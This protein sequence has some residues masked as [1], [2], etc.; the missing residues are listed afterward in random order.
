MLHYL[1]GSATDPI[2]TPA[3]LPH[4][5]N[6]KGR[7]GSGYVIAVSKKDKKPEEMYYRWYKREKEE[8]KDLPLGAVQ[9]CPYVDG[10]EVANMVGQ[11]DTKPIDGE[12]P[13]RYESLR[14]AL[15]SVYHYAGQ[16]NLTV[17]M[18]R[19]GAQRSGGDWNQIEAIIKEEMGDIETYVYTLPNEKDQWPQKYE[20]EEEYAKN[21]KN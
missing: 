12:P 1:I 3:L 14:Q 20:N 7:W 13:I 21:N 15:K 18:P 11:H 8:G 9:I 16:N 4:I 2:K 19:I 5:V 6:N 17:H 10:C